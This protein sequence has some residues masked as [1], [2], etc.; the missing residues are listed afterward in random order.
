MASLCRPAASDE[1]EIVQGL[2]VRVA[3]VGHLIT[4][5]LLAADDDRPQ[6][7][8]DVRALR[9][10]AVSED[11]DLARTAVELIDERG[12]ARGRDLRRSLAEVLREM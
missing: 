7:A 12:Y 4:L 2:H 10:V 9:D 1:L 6:D 11:E 3:R 8:M 5:K